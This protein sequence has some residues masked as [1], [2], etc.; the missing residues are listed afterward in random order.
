MNIVVLSFNYETYKCGAYHQDLVNAIQNIGNTF[1]YG[2]G[3]PGYNEKDEIGD[4][5]K[6]SGWIEAEIDYI[7][8]STSWEIQDPNILEF[9]PHPSIVLSRL[10]NVK[11]I[12]FLNKEYKKIDKKL[13]YIVKN[14]FDL[15]VTVLPEEKF[16]LWERK[17]KTKFIQSGFGIDINVF[18]DYS[19]KRKYDFFFTGALHS[20]Y[21]DLRGRL[22]REIFLNSK[23]KSNIG[24]QRIFYLKNPIK[25]SYR[26]YNI[27]WAEWGKW[28]RSITGRTLL[29]N[30]YEYAKLI[31]QAKTAFCS[32]SASGIIGPRFFELMACKTLILC[33]E[34]DYGEVLKNEEN[35]LMFKQD[36]SNFEE[37]LELAV[38][39]DKLRKKITDT[40]YSN[41]KDYTYDHHLKYILK[42]SNGNMDK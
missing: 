11:K 5:I 31:N 36:L 32:K 25:Q 8:V 23:I 14:Q 2:K 9:D 28:T 24:I 34:D 42:E 6:K 16:G 10:Q 20:D 33:P 29:P 26:K 19:L 22:K 12:Y 38:N 15:V 13:D 3:Y 17:T 40:A 30:G 27:Y 7:I 37:I 39:D 21:I 41:R 4:V 35:C 1:L 18:K